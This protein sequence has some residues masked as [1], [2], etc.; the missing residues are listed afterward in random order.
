MQVRKKI[1][2]FLTIEVTLKDEHE[3]EKMKKRIEDLNED[4]DIAQDDC[5]GGDGILNTSLL[6]T[7]SE[8]SNEKSS[9]NSNIMSNC[10]DSY[11]AFFWEFDLSDTYYNQK[12]L[13]VKNMIRLKKQV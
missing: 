4:P 11:S 6:D 1:I 3:K 10:E 9:H 13:K 12:N 2:I 5:S 7:K 8:I